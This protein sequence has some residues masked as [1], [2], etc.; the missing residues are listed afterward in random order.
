MT[1]KTT[2]ASPETSNPV[3]IITVFVSSPGDV[4]EER[5]VMDEICAS[6]NRT[7]GRARRFRLELFRWEHDVARQIGPKPQQVV[8]RQTPVYNIYLGIMSTR[9]GTPTDGCG[10]GT[11]KEFNDAVKKWKKAGTPWIT[12]YFR[13]DPPLSTKPA[14]VEQYLGVCRFRETLNDLGLVS[15]YRGVRG[16]KDGFYEKV[17]EHLRQILFQLPELKTA[18]GEPPEASKKKKTPSKPVVPPEYTAWLLDQCCDVDLL[19]LQPKHGAAVCLN[20]VYTPLTTAVRPE[21]DTPRGRKFDS[22]LLEEPHKAPQS[23]LDLLNKES[24]YVSGDPGTGKSTFCRWATWLI[25]NGIMPPMDVPAPEPYQEKF[26]DLLRGRLPVLVP[27]RDFWP[28]LGPSGAPSVGLAGLEKALDNWVMDQKPPGLDW[29]CVKAHLDNGSALLMLD[30]V[31]EVPSLHT[32]N[33]GEW[34]PRT[35]LLE[36]L[37]DAVGRWTK[38]NNRVLVTSRPYGLDAHQ[39]Q[40]LHLLPAPIQGWTRS[41]RRCWSAAGSCV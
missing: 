32:K 18:T 17:G 7:E 8:D 33:D 14:D 39:Q 6:I 4:S 36:V 37:A 25:C 1:K 11:E 23:L 15:S 22:E 35:M 3:Q 24:L 26:P 2:D 21:R 27:L 41:C 13:D 29:A 10:S 31:D 20:H 38:A 30:G 12:F 19:G 16:D 34:Y 40:K 9:F 5:A 28:H